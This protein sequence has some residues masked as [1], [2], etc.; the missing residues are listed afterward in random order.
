[1]LSQAPLQF[2]IAASPSDFE[3]IFRL[4]YQTFV[5]EIPQHPPN[6]DRR[7]VD[8]F[9]DENTYLVAAAGDEIVG[10][11]AMRGRRPFS[12]DEKL[13]G[14]V[15]TV[16]PAGRRV[17]ELR[18]LA[19]RREYR[20]GVVFRGLVDLVLRHGLAQGYDLAIISGTVRQLKLYRHLG[21]EPFGPII[22]TAD[23]PFQPMYLTI[24][25][26]EDSVPA[27]SSRETVSFLPGPVQ[28]PAAVRA[29]FERP[30]AYHRDSHFAGM[31]GRVKAQLCALAGAPR[32]ELLLGSGTLANDVVAAQIALLDEPGLVLSNG[33]FGERLI[34]HAARM[35]LRAAPL[36]AAWGD[37]I[38]LDRVEQAA[39]AMGARWLWGVVS[40]TS[41]GMLNDLEGWRDLSRRYGLSLCLDCVSAIGAVPLDLT[42]V[43]LAS[44]ASGKALAAFPGLSFVFY[45]HDARP[46][47]DR[48]PR[49]LDLGYYAAKGGVPFTQS[50]NLVAAL[51]AALARYTDADVFAGIAALSAQL[52]SRL[53]AVGL[54]L[55]VA[56]DAATPAV[57]TVPLPASVPASALGGW[58]E[59]QGLLVAYQSEYLAARNWLQ[60][61]VM[62]DC[63]QEQI[64]VLTDSIAVAVRS[65]Y[66]PSDYRPSDH[67]AV[68]DYRASD[69]R[70]SD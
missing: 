65:L 21:F 40:E 55:L 59:R 6:A 34:D 27:L 68:S 69:Y 52:R 66:R 43:Y 9:H 70:V 23:A 5:E 12:L 16:L 13:G 1:V 54:P 48:L 26:F 64:E 11:I 36:R 10:M 37:R 28:V 22:G 47:P 67:R 15:M 24:E 42:G 53:R 58:L 20:K 44:G 35:R 31:F 50:S 39:V 19:V 60:I 56:D 32:V 51:E 17:C 41:T 25:Q 18:L 4:N 49:Y 29:A 63:G 61:A 62:G 14:D 7:L 30:P 33:E 57:V 2:R 38:D 8:R 3:Q 45:A 46:A